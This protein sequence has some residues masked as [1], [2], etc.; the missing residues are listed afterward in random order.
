MY[1]LDMM[2]VSSGGGGEYTDFK[3]IRRKKIKDNNFNMFDQG[4]L[5]WQKISPINIFRKF[6]FSY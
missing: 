4:T 5:I 2:R 3:V 6:S 1:A